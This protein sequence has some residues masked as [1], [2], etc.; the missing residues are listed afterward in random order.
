MGALLLHQDP[1]RAWS[2]G[3][4]LAGRGCRVTASHDESD[5]LRLLERGRYR[6]VISELGT[7]S[8]FGLCLLRWAREHAP[9]TLRVGLSPEDRLAAASRLSR[10]DDLVLLDLCHDAALLLEIA[11]YG[12]GPDADENRPAGAPTLTEALVHAVTNPVGGEL[13]VRHRGEVG[14]VFAVEGRVAWCVAPGQGF[15]FEDLVAHG[16]ARHAL[17]RVLD[18]CRADR[19]NFAETLIREGHVDRA[20]MR[21]ILGRRIRRCLGVLLEWHEPRSLFVPSRRSFNS[22]LTFRL[23]EVCPPGWAGADRRSLP[24]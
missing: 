23:E 16:V 11:R 20:A 17:R 15:V 12:A 7:V 9:A 2:I 14:R 22:D 10:D 6:V 21:T 5:A 3:R 1:S 13:V 18:Q 8:S 19:A 4:L 24:S